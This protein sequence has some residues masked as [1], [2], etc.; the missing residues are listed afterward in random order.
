MF[1]WWDSQ[2]CLRPH[3]VVLLFH[4][5]HVTALL[6][7][8]HL[9]LAPVLEIAQK[10]PQNMKQC[11]HSHWTDPFHCCFFPALILLHLELF[12]DVDIPG[13]KCQILPKPLTMPTVL[14][15]KKAAQFCTD[16]NGLQ[17]GNS[18]Q[19][20]TAAVTLDFQVYPVSSTSALRVLHTKKQ[21][22]IK[23]HTNTTWAKQKVLKHKRANLNM[24]LDC[25]KIYCIKP[26]PLSEKIQEDSTRLLKIIHYL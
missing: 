17:E 8:K 2:P 25:H 24:R 21:R 14:L 11:H 12:G 13:M 19:P 10:D 1:C 23:H 20:A 3:S 4:L 16:R 9:I 5:S 7:N 15:P 6:M 18:L 26:L 22:S